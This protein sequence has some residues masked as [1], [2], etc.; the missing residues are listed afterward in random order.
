MFQWLNRLLNP[1]LN[2]L[3]RTGREYLRSLSKDKELATL[4]KE[5][6]EFLKI[7]GITEKG[8]RL[9]LKNISEDDFLELFDSQTFQDLMYLPHP[10]PMVWDRWGANR[11]F[12]HRDPIIILS[13]HRR[14]C[15]YLKLKLM[16]PRL[17]LRYET[18]AF[19]YFLQHKRKLP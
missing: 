8:L 5:E 14:T 19:N 10:P 2:Y 7:R 15:E 18:Y 4:Y 12:V 16:N 17:P 13:K 11:D 3:Q 6:I 9:F 1:R